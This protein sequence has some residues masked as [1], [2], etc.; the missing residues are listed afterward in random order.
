MRS[1]ETGHAVEAL[2]SDS[3]ESKMNAAKA[4]ARRRPGG[5]L[6][7]TGC[8]DERDLEESGVAH[9]RCVA[10]A[11]HLEVAGPA[12][13]HPIEFIYEHGY[14]FVALV[15]GDG[16][17]HVW[18][19]NHDMALGGEAI[20]DGLFRV[21]LQFHADPDDPLF[22]PEQ[23]LRLLAHERLQGRRQL[24]MNAGDDQFGAV[25]DALHVFWVSFRVAAEKGNVESLGAAGV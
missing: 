1:P 8:E 7:R 12:I 10:M 23:S 3:I 15:G 2:A 19:M 14:G 4:N 25:R 22:V 11:A 16:S 13:E 9:A 5:R 20:A 17:I 21:T 18:A 24:E 6:G